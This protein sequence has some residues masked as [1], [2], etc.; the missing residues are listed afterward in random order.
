MPRN[1]INF[2]SSPPIDYSTSID[3]SNSRKRSNTNILAMPH[4]HSLLPY[5]ITKRAD[6]C[7]MASRLP[8]YLSIGSEER[9]LNL[10]IAFAFLM[11]S[12]FSLAT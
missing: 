8:S 1:I 11:L 3:L 9:S 7:G 10:H 5:H 4:Y 2:A 6:D 12:D